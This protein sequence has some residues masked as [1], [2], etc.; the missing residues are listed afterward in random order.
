MI[1]KKYKNKINQW[2]TI[3]QWPGIDLTE[4]PGSV[5]VVLWNSL[6]ENP[7]QKVINLQCTLYGIYTLWSTSI[8]WWSMPNQGIRLINFFFFFFFKSKHYDPVLSLNS[9]THNIHLH[10]F[11][12]QTLLSKALVFIVWYSFYQFLICEL[13][14]W[15]C[16]YR[17]HTNIR[18]SQKVKTMR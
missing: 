16:S 9:P 12:C 2:S 17:K 13:N 5:L 1:I 14:L 6:K 3:K 15:A 10:K 18:P 11:I 8:E 7:K 4:D